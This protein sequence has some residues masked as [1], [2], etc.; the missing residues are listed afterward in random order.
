MNEPTQTNG[1]FLGRSLWFWLGM[2][3]ASTAM[4]SAL[5]I[6]GAVEHKGALMILLIVPAMTMMA[7]IAAV[8]NRGQSASGGCPAAGAAQR[9]YVKRV[10]ICSSLYLATFALM[11]F[12]DQEVELP[13]A[14]RV[15]IGILPGLAVSGIF[16]AIGR[17]I[18][19][20]QDEFMRM[21]IIRQSLIASAMALTSASVW[22]FLETADI[23][24]HIDAY[25]FAIIWFFG[26]GVG[27]IFNRIQYGTWGAV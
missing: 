18:V 1:T 8:V 2:T 13:F 26:L 22:G 14:V 19:E 6:T 23:A 4:V 15:M 17:L 9:R 7:I 27:A 25:W 5:A 20:E 16:W 3:A 12:L 24:P 10:A 21:L 11:T